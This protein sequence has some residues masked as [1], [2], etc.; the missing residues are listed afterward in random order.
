MKRADNELFRDLEAL[1]E[2]SMGFWVNEIDDEV[3]ELHNIG[4]HGKDSGG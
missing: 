3:W 1:S 2:S 4:N